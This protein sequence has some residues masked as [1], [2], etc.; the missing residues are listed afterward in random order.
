MVNVS[1]I[2]LG[3]EYKNYKELCN[4]LNENVKSGTSK[5]AQLKEWGK[6]LFI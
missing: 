2:E 3:K 4:A 5:K 1:L 6:I